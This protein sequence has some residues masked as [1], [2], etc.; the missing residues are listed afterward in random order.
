MSRFCHSGDVIV[1]MAVPLNLNTCIQHLRSGYLEESSGL[2]L[3][4][5]EVNQERMHTCIRTVG[6]EGLLWT[7]LGGVHAVTRR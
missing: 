7:I 5:S 6:R 1:V 2:R 4:Y 3:S